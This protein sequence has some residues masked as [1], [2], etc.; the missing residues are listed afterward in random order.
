MGKLHDRIQEDLLLKA[1]RPHTLRAYLGCARH[2]AKHYLRSPEDMGDPE[3]RDFLLHLVRD[4]MASPATL[5]MYVNALMFL[6]NVTLKR[7]RT[8][9]VILSPAEVIR[10]FGAIRPG[11]PG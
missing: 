2:F 10:I 9:P 3:I 1:Y 6:Y 8:M 7:P 4:R 11:R 5:S